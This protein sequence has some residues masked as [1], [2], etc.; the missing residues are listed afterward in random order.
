MSELKWIPE[1]ELLGG[2]HEKKNPELEL[3]EELVTY[4]WATETH[5]WVRLSSRLRQ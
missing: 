3:L 1:A 2:R 4:L 5:L